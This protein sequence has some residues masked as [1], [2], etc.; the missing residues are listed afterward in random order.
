MRSQL[1]AP[2][3]VLFDLIFVLKRQPD[4]VESLQQTLAAKW[5]DLKAK[6]EPFII[7]HPLPGQINSQFVTGVRGGSLEELIDLFFRKH[8]REH[9]VL[10]TIAVEDVRE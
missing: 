9:A 4:V 7:G 1:N 3:F 5:I 10:E 6:P 2:R 8:D